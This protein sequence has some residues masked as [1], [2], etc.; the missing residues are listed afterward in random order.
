MPILKVRKVNQRLFYYIPPILLHSSNLLHGVNNFWHIYFL[1]QK[2]LLFICVVR[3]ICS[4]SCGR[5]SCQWSTQFYRLRPLKL[6]RNLYGSHHKILL[7]F[8]AYYKNGWCIFENF[9]INA[10][11]LIN[12][13]RINR[14]TK[15]TPWMFN[16]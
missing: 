5:G 14:K 9:K 10:H 4:W 3:Q 1:K 15:L 6:Q 16:R 12:A 13:R 2:H 7:S 8:F 11:F